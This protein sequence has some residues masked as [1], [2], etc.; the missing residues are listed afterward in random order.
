MII[1]SENATKID[2]YLKDNDAELGKWPIELSGEKKI[3]PFYKFPLKL[4]YYNINNGRFA[5]EKRKKEKDIGR[6]LN[7]LDKEDAKKLKTFCLKFFRIK[8]KH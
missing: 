6:E 8:Q 1:N 5:A 2:S 4:L 3:V 7:P